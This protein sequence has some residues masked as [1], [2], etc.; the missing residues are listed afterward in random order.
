MPVSITEYTESILSMD[1]IL[2]IGFDDWVINTL[3]QPLYIR[4]LQ[5]SN[6]SE[7]SIVY[8]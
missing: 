7:A 6:L 2:I 4:L 5:P 1:A 3:S 8:N